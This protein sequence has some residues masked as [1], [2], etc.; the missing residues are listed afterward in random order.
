MPGENPEKKAE[1]A[2]QITIA[3]GDDGQYRLA[4]GTIVYPQQD[5]DNVVNKVRNGLQKQIEEI[6]SEF[7]TQLEA[8]KAK[9]TK[10]K[11]TVEEQMNQ[12]IDKLTAAL[13]EF[14][15]RAEKAEQQR[16]DDKIN[17]HLLGLAAKSPLVETV[18][19]SREVRNFRADYNISYRDGG[20]FG[21]GA[22][23]ENVPAEK[24]WSQY[25]SSNAHLINASTRGGSGGQPASGAVDGKYWTQPDAHLRLNEFKD[26]PR[27]YKEYKAAKEQ[28]IRNQ[29]MSGAYS[30]G[31]ISNLTKGS[32]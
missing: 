31:I 20:Y 16:M 32:G 12:R 11:M 6:K 4:D 17:T 15:S 26:D 22:N 13:G 2:E 18:N 19:P 30:G 10:E 27:K 23:G 1:N 21:E 3:K 9:G 8:E 14:Q 7:Q 5:L 28:R 24:L 25:L 29:A